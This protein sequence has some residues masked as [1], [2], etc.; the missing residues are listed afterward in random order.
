MRLAGGAGVGPYEMLAA[1]G[2]GGM[3]EVYRARDMRLKREVSVKVLPR[4]FATDPGRRQRFE[5]EARAVAT[6]NNPNIIAVYDAGMEDSTPCI[7]T[8][9][10]D[11][12]PLRAGRS[13]PRESRSCPAPVANG[14]P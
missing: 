5:F 10:V 11:G 13:A 7:G 9:L 4:E 1:L 2:A 12:E 6:P 8:E 3:G 14:P